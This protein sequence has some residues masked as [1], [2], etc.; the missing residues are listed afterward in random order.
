MEQQTLQVAPRETGLNKTAMRNHRQAGKIPATLFGKSFESRPVFIEA[1]ATKTRGWHAGSM[2]S[3]N[4]DGQK[5]RAC[6][7][8]IQRAATGNE[9]THLSFHVIRNDEVIHVDLPIAIVGRAAGEK[10]GG[11]TNITQKTISV[12]GLPDAIPACIE[13]NVESLELGTHLT[14]NE[15][16]L[17]KG[18]VLAETNANETVVYCAQPR[19]GSLT[20]ETATAVPAADAATTAAAAST[21][22]NQ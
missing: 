16:K 13:I 21:T 1:K 5:L 19:V 6:L 9:I 18:L 4:W 17:P 8:E 7:N 12:R 3:F 14:F 15:I 2:F 10:A 11:L 22:S 20:T